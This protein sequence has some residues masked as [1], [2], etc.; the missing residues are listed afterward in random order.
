M[1]TSQLRDCKILGDLMVY[2]HVS[3]RNGDLEDFYENLEYN[4]TIS[5]VVIVHDA[6][7]IDITSRLKKEEL[8]ELQNLIEL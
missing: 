2:Y 6:G 4:K 8:I 1:S 5:K 7:E 3:F